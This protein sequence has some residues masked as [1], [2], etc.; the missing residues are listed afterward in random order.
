MAA[1]REAVAAIDPLAYTLTEAIDLAEGLDVET[2]YSLWRKSI[3]KSKKSYTMVGAIPAAEIDRLK[4]AALRLSPEAVEEEA[5][6][7]LRDRARWDG[8]T[9]VETRPFPNAKDDD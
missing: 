4:A 3:M 1:I 6:S 7:S 5:L 9:R 2:A 8:H